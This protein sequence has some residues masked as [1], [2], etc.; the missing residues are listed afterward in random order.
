[1]RS[2]LD[3][4]PLWSLS[5][6]WWFYIL[7]F[8][9]EK[10]FKNKSFQIVCCLAIVSA[11]TYI[12]Y[13]F[14]LNRLLMYLIIWWAGVE[15][16]KVYAE[17]KVFSINNLAKPLIAILICAALMAINVAVHFYQ[18]VKVQ[19]YPFVELRH[20]GASIVVILVSLLWKKFNWTFFDKTIGIFEAIAPISYTIYISHYFL[21]I[22]ADYLKTIPSEAVRV[23]LGLIICFIFLSGRKKDLSRS[24]E[25]TAAKEV[26]RLSIVNSQPRLCAISEIENDSMVF[27]C[28]FELSLF[29]TSQT[30]QLNAA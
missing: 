12:F 9:I 11:L 5:Y 13:P 8:F 22:H 6:E 27:E 23:F 28:L 7:Y 17:D 30:L 20:M 14:F 1:M 24:D 3:N 15:I 21:V 26:D 18:P 16:A 19:S 25:S 10:Y 29:A 2:I 4:G